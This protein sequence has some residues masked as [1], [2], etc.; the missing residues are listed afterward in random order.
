MWCLLTR[1]AQ[2]DTTGIGN[3]TNV[4][5]SIT[6]SPLPFTGEAVGVSGGSG[7]MVGLTVGVGGVV[8]VLVGWF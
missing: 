2:A 4:S 6:A 5:T 8:G 1:C 7:G 3:L